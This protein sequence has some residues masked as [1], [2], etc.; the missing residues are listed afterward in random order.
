MSKTRLEK[1]ADWDE[2][3]AQIKNRQKMER[4]LHAKEERAAR[5]RRLCSRYGLLESMMPEIITITDEQYKA[6]L[7]KAVTNQYGRD[8]LN[9][10]IAQGAGNGNPK[11]S[12]AASQTVEEPSAT[13]ETPSE[14][15]ANPTNPRPA[16][17]KQQTTAANTAKPIAID[18][19]GGNANSGNTGG[20]ATV[21]G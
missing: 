19:N 3:I 9:K 11:P 16:E 20:G 21:K 12:N 6:F 13:K 17:P 15:N 8:I 7:E 18:N 5:T 14:P 2:Q 4:Q 1:I 10:V